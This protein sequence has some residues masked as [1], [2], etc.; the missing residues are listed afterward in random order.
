VTWGNQLEFWSIGDQ[1]VKF[2]KIGAM[3]SE[4][5]ALG[6][7]GKLRQWKWEAPKP[8]EVAFDVLLEY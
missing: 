7:D 1:G 6:N 8:N 5:V 4:L 2:E 3:Y